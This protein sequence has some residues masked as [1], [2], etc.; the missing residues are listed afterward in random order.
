[1]PSILEDL[2]GLLSSSVTK[3]LGKA[4]G[5]KPDLVTKGIG[6]IGGDRRC[7]EGGV[8]CVTPRSRVRPRLHRGGTDQVHEVAN[9]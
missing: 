5:L 6:V 1:M 9:A 4:V 2:T 8:T 7:G 3:D